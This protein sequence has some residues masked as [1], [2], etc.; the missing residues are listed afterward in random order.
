M[1]KY[2]FLL[3]SFVLINMLFARD[4]D[5]EWRRVVDLRGRWRFEI[6]DNLIWATP[7]FDDSDWVKIFAPSN[8]E[9]EGYPG[10]DGYAWYRKKFTLK[11]THNLFIHLGTIDDVDQVYINGH[12]VGA[13]GQFPPEYFTGYN[14]ERIYAIPSILLKTNA[15]NTIAIRVYDAELE[16]G[17][18]RG[19]LGIY[20]K[21]N[22]PRMLLS[23]EGY[24]RF[25]TGDRE[26]W[27]EYNY[28]D[29]YWDKVFVPMS[30][31][32]QGYEY[33]G[34]GWY[35]LHFRI[36]PKYKNEKLVMLLGKIDDLDEAYLNGNYIGRTGY[37]SDNPR[38]IEVDNEY[39]AYRAYKIDEDEIYFD[40]DNVLAVRVYDG[41][42]TGGI[43]EGPVGIVS[44]DEYLAWR[45][46][47]R[48]QNEVFFDLFRFFNWD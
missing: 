34:Y 7:E 35:R 17:L 39:L 15:E 26:E 16:G 43:Y 11:D 30:W 4:P 5:Q 25:S 6:G 21:L 3:I 10:Y 42:I 41:L 1:Y 40:R 12:L 22:A 2:I 14:V 31:E 36:D 19:K 45:K 23:L 24:W 9:D 37:I 48:T 18:V 27:A 8:W 28:D 47:N 20:E 38:R 13:A 32:A 29:S 33:D 46:K 44:Y